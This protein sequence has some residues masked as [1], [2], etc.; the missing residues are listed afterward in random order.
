VAEDG[1]VW[2]LVVD[3]DGEAVDGHGVCRS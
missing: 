1:F 2:G 3:E